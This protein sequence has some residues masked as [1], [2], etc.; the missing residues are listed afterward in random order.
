MLCMKLYPGTNSFVWITLDEYFNITTHFKSGKFITKNK[1]V[2]SASLTQ[3]RSIDKKNVYYK[4]EMWY[5]NI[6]YGKC[7]TTL[8]V[9][10]NSDN[11]VWF[12]Y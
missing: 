6:N 1:I 4:G 3:R 8:A 12:S 11:F 7:N 2:L 9:G 5:A 10:K